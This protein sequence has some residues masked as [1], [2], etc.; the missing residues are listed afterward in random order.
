MYLDQSEGPVITLNEKSCSSCTTIPSGKLG[1]PF[2]LLFD[3]PE[4][5][6]SVVGSVTTSESLVLYIILFSFFSIT[7]VM[8][9]LCQRVF[10]SMVTFLLGHGSFLPP[11]Y[12]IS[13]D[14]GHGPLMDKGSSG[15]E[16]RCETEWVC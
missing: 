9:V 13:S 3:K 12:G 15:D 11:W 14:Q 1:I 10:L 16:C 6:K 7:S 2:A 4:R 8:N 5:A